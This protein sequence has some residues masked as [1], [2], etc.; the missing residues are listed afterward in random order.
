MKQHRNIVERALFAINIALVLVCANGYILMKNHPSLIPIFF[1]ALILSNFLP[2]YSKKRFPNTR[3]RICHHGTKCLVL[4]NWT[5]A[6]SIVFHI[7]MAFY[8]FPTQWLQ[9]ILSA[10]VCTLVEAV[11]F[12]NG[13][14]SVYCTSVQL[15]IKHR[16]L[17]VALGWIPVANLIMLQK[18][19][20]VTGE[21]VSFETGKYHINQARHGQEICKTRY[22]LLLVHGVFFRDTKY[23]DY[24]GRVPK[25]L[26]YNG[27]R[28]YYGEHQSAASIESSAA[29]LSARIKKIV[30][31]T[32]CEK[33][34]IIAHSK[35]GL[36][37]RFAISAMNLSPFVASLTTIN[38]PHRGCEFVDYL[39]NKAPKSVVHKVEA[40]YNA[41]L[42]KLGDPSP[43]FIAAM[44]DLTFQRC[45]ELDKALALADGVYFQSV[46]AKLNGATSGKF[47][48]NFAYH[49]VKYFDGAN[50]GLVGEKSFRFGENY[51][52]LKVSGK[53]G[54]SHGD[55]ID[56]N[57]ENIP[58][59]DIREFYVQLVSDLRQRGF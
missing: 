28:I 53:R 13:I 47:P 3:T 57:R 20:K 11:V 9:W 44:R 49:L 42:K 23:L 27:A 34:N 32:G 29:E 50:D 12:W 45:A 54:I 56:L 7:I 35:G 21:E 10:V 4:F 46:G 33:V 40:A 39:L 25:E 26:T 6:L 48:L 37:C 1:G 22:P 36:D 30:A 52:F 58:G 18:I 31:E 8:L 5:V 19:V 17:G 14:I 38:T 55:M 43:D 16:V 59:F 15:G 41:T 2:L 24:W 51:T